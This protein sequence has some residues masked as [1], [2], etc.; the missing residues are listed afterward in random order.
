MGKKREFIYLYLIQFVIGLIW[1]KSAY[2]KFA[3]VAFSAN[4]SKTLT[5]FASKNPFPW[6]AA[7]LQNWAIPNAG[8]FAELTRWGELVAA[9][10]LLV[11]AVS[12]MRNIRLPHFHRL[13]TLGAL[14]GAFLNLQFGLAAG[15]TSPSTETL[16]LLMLLIQILF[17]FYQRSVAM[18]K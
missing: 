18:K 15:W 10:L 8:L 4:L 14:I 13:A 12:A 6:Y 5:L 2:A 17:I 1:L 16:N 3:G 9:V 11:T 7:F